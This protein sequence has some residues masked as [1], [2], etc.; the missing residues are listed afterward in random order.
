MSSQ[1]QSAISLPPQI[2]NAVQATL[3]EMIEGLFAKLFPNFVPAASAPAH[4]ASAPAM[5]LAPGGGPITASAPDPTGTSEALFEQFTVYDN[6]EDFIASSA[7]DDA[8]KAAVKADVEATRAKTEDTIAAD[9]QAATPAG[10]AFPKV[11]QSASGDFY[12][13]DAATGKP[14]LNKVTITPST[15]IPLASPPA[16]TTPGAA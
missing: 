4:F 12:V 5:S 9:I 11:V 7:L 1:P 8:T 16:A 10:Q 13:I 2:V 3:L 15:D 6:V 14:H